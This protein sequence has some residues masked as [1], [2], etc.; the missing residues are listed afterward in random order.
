MCVRETHAD[1]TVVNDLCVLPADGSAE[2]RGIVAGHDFFMAPRVSADGRRL[3]WLAW[4]HPRMPWDG[5]ELWV[6]DLGPDGTPSGE[7]LVAG[8]PEESI[9]QPEWGP[10]GTLHFISDRT[11]W[12]NLHRED[13]PGR[14]EALAPMDADVG[15]PAWGFGVSRYAFLPGGRIALAF[16]RAGFERLGVLAPGATS[17][18]ELD[19]PYARFREVRAAGGRLAVSAGGPAEPMQVAAIDPGTGGRAV[20]QRTAAPDVEPG[21]VSVP[22]PIEFPT[23]GGQTAHALLYPP[24]NAAATGPAGERPPLV[25]MSHGGPTS[26]TLP[27]Y[28]PVVQFFT[29]R[30]I[31][32]ADVNYRGSSGYGRDYRNRL[33]GAWGVADAA[34]C[35]N[36]AR[37]LA[38]RGE[39]D[40]RRMA[41]RGASAGG[42]ATLCAL[43]FHDVFAAGASYFGIGDLEALARDTHKFESRYLDLLVGP[44]PQEAATYRERSP[45]RFPERISCPVILFQGLEDAVV[46]PS[47]ARDM[48]RALGA[49]GVPHAVVFFDGEQHGFRR[50]E[51]IERSLLLELAF[52]GRVFGF[53]LAD[54]VPPLELEPA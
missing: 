32:V 49:N 43:T 40:G 51:T 14:V 5:T 30:G 7:R 34:D 45:V 10:D 50:A 18:R 52:Y 38:E 20:L 27:V 48:A 11:G 15:V 13:G 16:G 8:G 23:E 22:R 36:A 21:S 35:V 37:W 44:Y 39:V 42:Y 2:P 9:V 26:Q 3:A 17:P 53:V 25:V 47:Q 24:A 46:P 6:A 12:W 1:G 41:I 33:R 29:S 4:D 28:S 54:D 19:L 31:A